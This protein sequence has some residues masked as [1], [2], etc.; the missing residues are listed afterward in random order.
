MTAARRGIVFAVAMAVATLALFA[1]F[2]RPVPGTPFSPVRTVVSDPNTWETATPGLRIEGAG[3][4]VHGADAAG[5]TLL[6]QPVTPFDAASLRH[7]D[8]DLEVEPTDKAHFLWRVGGQLRN[9]PLPRAAGGKGTIDLLAL[10][11]WEGEVDAIGIAASPTDMLHPAFVAGRDFAVRSLRLSSPSWKGALAALWN[12]WTAYRPWTGRSNNT[13]GF[14]LAAVAGP[15]LPLFVAVLA[16]IA[17]LLVAMLSGREAARRAALPI[18]GVAAFW[19]AA[20]QLGQLAE[21]GSAAKAA[22]ARAATDPELPLSAQ[23]LLAAS[24]RAV[25]TRLAAE[26]GRPRVFV[27]GENQFLGEYATWLL[28]KHNA[29]VLAP[30][31]ALPRTFDAPAFLVLAGRGPWQFDVAA[32]RLTIGEGHWRAELIHDGGLLSAYRVLAAEGAP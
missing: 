6:M 11:G 16:A 21:R 18:V 12:E 3:V 13:G 30:L 29:A 22:A 4:V 32:G 15:S 28:R 20:V 8:Y 10:P 1:A 5:T 17:V 31:E 7:L 14:E 24:A 9:A 23:P 27:G 2:A 19:L 26:P 25:S